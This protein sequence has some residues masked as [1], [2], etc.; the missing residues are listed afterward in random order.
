[1]NEFK[2]QLKDWSEQNGI[3]VDPVKEAA[4]GKKRTESFSRRDWEELMGR[5][6]PTYKRGRGGTIKQRY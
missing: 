3:E 1:M 6:K 4:P 2:K 5:N